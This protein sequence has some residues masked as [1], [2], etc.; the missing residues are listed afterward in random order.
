VSYFLDPLNSSL[1][2]VKI[3]WLREVRGP[4]DTPMVRKA[5]G[6][7]GSKERFTERT[8]MNRFGQPEE[9]AEVICW[10]LCEGSSYV[11]GHVHTVDGGWIA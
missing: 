4:I 5:S 7:S 11:T 9:V 10:L 3:E 1:E 6:Q 8:L 2:G